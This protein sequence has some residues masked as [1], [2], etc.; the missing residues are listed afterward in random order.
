MIFEDN[1][2]VFD[3]MMH[4]NDQ[5]ALELV[6]EVKLSAVKYAKMRLEWAFM[7]IEER[8]QKDSLRT[9]MHD[10]FI[11][12]INILNRYLEKNNIPEQLKVF[13]DRKIMGDFACYIAYQLMLDMR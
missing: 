8:S 9:S 1:Y 4:L 11:N 6:E 10:V 5:V 7:T 13:D 2:R 3:R 12:N